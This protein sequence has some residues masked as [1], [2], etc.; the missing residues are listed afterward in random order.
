MEASSGGGSCRARARPDWQP[1]LHSAPG[2]WLRWGDG[3]FEVIAWSG[4]PWTGLQLSCRVAISP[5]CLHALQFS[6][7]NSVGL[8]VP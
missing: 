5:G 7:G 4:P 3:D 2:E 8:E 1:S 6:L